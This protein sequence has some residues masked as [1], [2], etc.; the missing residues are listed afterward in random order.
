MSMRLSVIVLLVL[1]TVCVATA[2]GLHRTYDERPH[3]TYPSDNSKE[4]LLLSMTDDNVD[5]LQPANAHHER[6]KPATTL[7]QWYDIQRADLDF[8]TTA[9]ERLRTERR[10]S[11]MPIGTS[12]PRALI[13]IVRADIA[14]AQAQAELVNQLTSF[15]DH[16]ALM[17]EAAGRVKRGIF[18]SWHGRRTSKHIREVQRMRHGYLRNAME[19]EK[20]ANTLLFRM[21]HSLTMDVNGREMVANMMATE[22]FHDDVVMDQLS[23]GNDILKRIRIILDALLHKG[24]SVIHRT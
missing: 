21:E 9:I 15:L 3:V 20:R 19:L 18:Q 12:N 22:Q 2:H 11:P 4:P 6:H 24:E 10:H 1:P 23:T 7:K 5:D 13:R 16:P 14:E 8:L 17:A